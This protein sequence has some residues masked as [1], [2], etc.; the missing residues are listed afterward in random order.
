MHITR[1]L[2]PLCVSAG[3]RIPDLSIH[4]MVPSHLTAAGRHLS[5]SWNPCAATAHPRDRLHRHER[6]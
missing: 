4:H 2:V 1:F 5:G 6:A 3:P